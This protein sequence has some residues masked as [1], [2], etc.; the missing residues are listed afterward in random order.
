LVFLA[1]LIQLDHN[2]LAILEEGDVSIQLADELR[3]H[4]PAIGA[5]PSP[6][7]AAR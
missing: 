1:E 4:S 3:L 2:Q 6:K 7:L 5:G